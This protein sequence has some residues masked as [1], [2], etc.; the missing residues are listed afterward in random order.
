M[1]ENVTKLKEQFISALNKAETANDVDALRIEYS[2]KKG[3]VSSLM[4]DLRNIPNE[5][6]KEA[7]MELTSLSSLLKRNLKTKLWLLS[8]LKSKER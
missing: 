1:F 2:G 5:Q 8:R 7:G 4:N 3:L 6:K